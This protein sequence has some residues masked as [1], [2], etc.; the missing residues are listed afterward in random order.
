MNMG[1]CYRNLHGITK[2]TK[3]LFGVCLTPSNLI[4]L[5]VRAPTPLLTFVRHT[6]SALKNMSSFKKASLEIFSNAITCYWHQSLQ[7]GSVLTN[8]E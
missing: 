6:Q 8:F 1:N 3:V 5:G 2:E 7:M 4:C